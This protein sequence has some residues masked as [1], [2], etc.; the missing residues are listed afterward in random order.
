MNRYFVVK[1]FQQ[2]MLMFWFAQTNWMQ[3]THLIFKLLY[4]IFKCIS[5][6]VFVTS[7]IETQ[8]LYNTTWVL[9][10]VLLSYTGPPARTILEI[11]AGLS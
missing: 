1:K 10:Q 11:L 7:N 4:H 8:V 3:S 9:G 5:F 2:Y 6:G